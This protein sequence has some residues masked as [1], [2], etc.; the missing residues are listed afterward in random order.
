MVNFIAIKVRSMK[1]WDAGQRGGKDGKAVAEGETFVNVFTRLI[2]KVRRRFVNVYKSLNEGRV[3]LNQ[4]IAIFTKL[5]VLGSW[6]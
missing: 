2:M 6:V 3:A 5:R 4:F 1:I